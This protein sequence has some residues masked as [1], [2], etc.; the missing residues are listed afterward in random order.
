MA[1]PRCKADKCGRDA[2][3]DKCDDGRF[4]E[5]EWVRF[6][7]EATA[8]WNA[9]PAAANPFGVGRVDGGRRWN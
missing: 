4:A 3:Y 6:M 5:G 7:R 1:C 9:L 8:K 2:G